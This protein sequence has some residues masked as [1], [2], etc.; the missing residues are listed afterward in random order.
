MVFV[1]L[2]RKTRGKVGAK[3][4]KAKLD[5]EWNKISSLIEKRKTGSGGGGS[6][7]KV[8]KME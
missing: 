7:A 2:G 5:R 3:N 6:S 1:Y 8:A 4:E